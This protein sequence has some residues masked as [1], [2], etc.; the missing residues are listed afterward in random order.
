MY[1]QDSL[2]LYTC[3]WAP[4]INPPATSPVFAAVSDLTAHLFRFPLYRRGVDVSAISSQ[5]QPG[6]VTRSKSVIVIHTETSYCA[7]WCAFIREEG[8]KLCF[9][10]ADACDIQSHSNFRLREKFE[11]GIYFQT[12]RENIAYCSPVGN[13]A[14]FDP[15]SNSI[16]AFPWSSVSNWTVALNTWNTTRYSEDAG[17][18]EDMADKDRTAQTQCRPVKVKHTELDMMELDTINL[19]EVGMY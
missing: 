19:E 8:G 14:L 5:E 16:T 7:F 12:A 6:A 15:H 17:R 2:S 3:D 9:Q 18:R 10:T 1:A 13:V 11:A 4:L